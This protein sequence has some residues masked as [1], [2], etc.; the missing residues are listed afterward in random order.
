MHVVRNEPKCKISSKKFPKIF[1]TSIMLFLPE[2]Q[3]RQT[4]LEKRLG[5][6]GFL[7]VNSM[8]LLKNI[9]SS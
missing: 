7:D 8:C 6:F 5:D 1:F 4:C 3:K 9:S 2:K